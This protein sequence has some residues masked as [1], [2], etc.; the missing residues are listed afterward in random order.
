MIMIWARRAYA[1]QQMEAFLLHDLRRH[2]ALDVSLILHHR[3]NL[4]QQL[5]LEM[6]I[7]SLNLIHISLMNHQLLAYQS[8]TEPDE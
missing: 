8:L 4:Q 5:F 1:L 2:S 7:L 6:K 3:L